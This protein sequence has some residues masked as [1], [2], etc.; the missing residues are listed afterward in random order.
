MKIL[1]TGFELFGKVLENPSQRVVEHF[2]AKRRD[3][4]ITAIL[5]VDYISASAILQDLLESHKPDAVLMLGVAQMRDSIS[6]ERI[7][8][9]INDASIADNAGN[10]KSG[11]KI[12][13]DA[14]AAYW[15]TLPLES[16]YEAIQNAGIAVNYS[17]HA[18]A[19]LCNHVFYYARHWL[20]N[21]GLAHIPCGFIH[22]PDMGDEAPKMPLEKMIRAVE[23]C[24][25]VW[26]E[27]T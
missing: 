19:Y 15:S 9:N 16:M 7:A 4:L 8:I 17:N 18:G 3:N 13:E 1:L 25:M 24:L 11:Q 6:L 23:L 27:T 21:A 26:R 22:L 14:P 10:Q 5:P 20:E 12:V 2:A